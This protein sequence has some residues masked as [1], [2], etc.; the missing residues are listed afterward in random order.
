MRKEGRFYKY[1]G[2]CREANHGADKPHV[3]RFKMPAG[4]GEVGF[5]DLVLGNIAKPYADLDDWV[6]LRGDGVPLYNYGCVLD[7]HLME[8]SLVVRGQEHI[9]STLPQLMLYRALGWE[10]PRF[11]HL[12]LILGPDREKLSKR[13]HPEA[14][15]MRHKA[16]GILPEALLNYI[17]RLG[18]SHGDDEIISREQMME[19]FDF[20][21]VGSTSGVWDPVKLLWLNQQWLK[22][23]PEARIAADLTPFLAEVGV[24]GISEDRL[25]IAVRAFRDRTQSLKEMA[26]TAAPYFKPGVTYDEKAAAKQLTADS[27]PRL[28]EVRERLAGTA[29]LDPQTIDGWVKEIA[30]KAGLGMG[31]VAQ[32]LRVAVT[33]NTASPGIGETLCLIGRDECLRRIDAALARIG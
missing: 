32:P 23:L 31:K 13:K 15:V 33:G 26:A 12:P 14:D 5:D 21:H 30:E 22:R 11:A 1:E 17:V 2:T 16:E 3:I 4:E 28:L 29:A 6:M 9:N 27:K 7:D 10:P 20:D 19:W 18:W 24:S 25:L 8:M